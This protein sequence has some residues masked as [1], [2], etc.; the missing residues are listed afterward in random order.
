[1]FIKKLIRNIF[2]NIYV[3]FLGYRPSYFL[4]D[5]EKTNMSISDAFFG[6]QIKVLRQFLNLQIF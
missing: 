4:I 2:L 1:M 6:E 3:I 5:Y